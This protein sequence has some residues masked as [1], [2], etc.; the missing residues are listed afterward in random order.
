MGRT[1]ACKTFL[2]ESKRI[3]V[4]ERDRV[5]KV[6][7]YKDS[8]HLTKIL[9]KKKAAWFVLQCLQHKNKRQLSGP[10]RRDRIKCILAELQGK[11]SGIDWIALRMAHGARPIILKAT[12]LF[13]QR[14]IYIER[15][16]RDDVFNL[17]LV[18]PHT[19]HRTEPVEVSTDIVNQ[20]IRTYHG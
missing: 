17:R 2:F 10:V 1:P 16:D 15:T 6:T 9:G 14:L 20:A 7:L 19:T 3:V 4:E 12:R 11:L 13:H 8:W 5:F 18:D